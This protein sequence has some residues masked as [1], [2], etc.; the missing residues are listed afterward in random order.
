MIEFTDDLCVGPEIII[1]FSTQ[2]SVYHIAFSGFGVGG[3]ERQFQNLSAAVGFRQERA[4]II[5]S[6]LFFNVIIP[7]HN[8]KFVVQSFFDTLII[9]KMEVA[10]FRFKNTESCFVAEKILLVKI[11]GFLVPS[12]F[13]HMNRFGFG[14]FILFCPFQQFKA[15]NGGGV[16]RRVD[17]FR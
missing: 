4:Q 15:G 7:N 1:V 6:Q 16:V 2:N 8:R 5:F 14:R 13:F 12:P 11:L 10:E 17:G 3:L 9:V